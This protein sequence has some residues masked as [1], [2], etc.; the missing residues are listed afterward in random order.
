MSSQHKSHRVRAHE[1]FSAEEIERGRRYHRP[2]YML[3]GADLALSL[4][5]LALLAGPAGDA[6]YEPFDGLHWAVATAAYGV[7][8]IV[9]LAVLRLPISLWRGY[10]RE[11][12]F[13]LSTQ[14]LHGWLVDW[15]KGLAIS[16]ALTGAALVGLVALV[17]WL[18]DGWPLPAALAAAAFVLLVSFVGPL[19]LEPIFN[20][21]EPVRDERLHASLRAL[22]NRAG[23]PV[24]DVL[25][26]DASRRTLR[27]N[28]YVSGLGASRRVVLFDTLL[29]RGSQREVEVVVAHELAHR[30]ER[31][32]VKFT[33]LGMAGAVVAVAVLWLVIGERAGDPRRIPLVLLLAF[34]LELVALPPVAA[35][36]RRWERGA[37]R[38]A[39]EL[40]GDAEA[41]ESAYRDLA[42]A[43]IADLDPPRALHVLL[44]TH[45]T[46]PE[47][48]AAA[49]QFATVPP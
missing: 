12:S 24:R 9:L 49:R 28:A 41:L 26:C 8:V 1:L 31:H 19:V 35:L 25:V 5:V 39:L 18:P 44:A 29:Q 13:G 10:V 21:F 2:L 45:P 42:A 36:S 48:I 33:L 47:R 11:R 32:V 17:R 15:A 38:L 23:T 22:A 34:A 30:R 37:D 4:G 40:T 14:S 27:S 46:I 16:V 6:L 7:L 20:R 3:L 43:N